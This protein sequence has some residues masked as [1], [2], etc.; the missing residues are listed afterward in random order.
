MTDYVKKQLILH[1]HDIIINLEV[2]DVINRMLDSIE[3]HSNVSTQRAI[4]SDYLAIKEA[5]MV[6]INRYKLMKKEKEDISNGYN[7]L[8]SRSAELRDQMIAEIGSVLRESRRLAVYKEEIEELKLNLADALDEI[9]SFKSKARPEIASS[10]LVEDV[11]RSES[12]FKES[13]SSSSAS[14]VIKGTK[15]PYNSSAQIVTTATVVAVPSD[16][17]KSSIIV[18]KEPKHWSILHELEGELL[19]RAFSFLET[20]DVLSAAQVCKYVYAK[21]YKLFGLE[22]DNIVASWRIKPGSAE[23]TAAALEPQTN[24]P[25]RAVP[26]SREN[27]AAN[28]SPAP[29]V[30]GIMASNSVTG[31]VNM[32]NAFNLFSSAASIPSPSMSLASN[33]LSATNTVSQAAPQ[34]FVESLSKKLTGSTLIRMHRYCFGIGLL[35]VFVLCRIRVENHIKYE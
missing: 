9:E 5:M 28:I 30:Q 15:D 3:R 17:S 4:L 19:L 2:N 32:M 10:N 8:K 18:M 21:V 11:E 33:N 31:S 26:V 22:S 6:L 29:I 24:T 12:P 20:I 1:H 23:A 25:I 13:S 7:S 35:I 14:S 34:N 27:S 16:P